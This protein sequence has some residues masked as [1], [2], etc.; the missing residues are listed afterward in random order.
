[1]WDRRAR[2]KGTEGTGKRM[3]ASR[4]LGVRLGREE[5]ADRRG[6]SPGGAVGE[7]AQWWRV[8][9]RR[10]VVRRENQSEPSWESWGQGVAMGGGHWAT[11]RKLN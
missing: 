5:G 8:A 6:W 2:N 11:V 3:A 10:G 9:R 1:M 7:W 4:R